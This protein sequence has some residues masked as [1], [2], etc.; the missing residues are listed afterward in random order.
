M[1]GTAILPAKPCFLPL[2][3]SLRR[4]M[5]VRAS[6]ASVAHPSAAPD[7]RC[8][9]E[10]LRVR[11][12]AS[13]VEIKTAYRTLAKL[14]H[15]DA[16]SRFLDSS[17]AASSSD[18]GDFIEIHNAYATLSDPDARAAYDFNL[19]VNSQRRFSTGGYRSPG[20]GRFQSTRRWETD[21]CW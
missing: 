17:A 6:V 11:R 5:F 9:Y 18:G 21:Q 7:R 15:P 3:Q 12:N 8:L 14:Y 19:N 13:P 16:T 1:L 20:R 10:V 4:Q 2:H